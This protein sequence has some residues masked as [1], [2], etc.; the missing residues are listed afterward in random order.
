MVSLWQDLAPWEVPTALA[1]VV[2]TILLNVYFTPLDALPNSLIKTHTRIGLLPSQT[3]L[4]AQK[5]SPL[6]GSKI[7]LR[8]LWI[9]P[10][11]SC[12]GIEL[13]QSRVLPTGL[14]F[15]RLFTF[16]QLRGDETTWRFLTQR[17]AP[18]LTNLSV[19]VWLANS[20]DGSGVIV[21]KFP[22]TEK[23][24]RGWRQ[25]I[26]N[27]LTGGTY[28]KVFT[29]PL[30]FPSKGDI[31][32]KAYK[33]E[34]VKI[35]NNVTTALNMIEAVPP[36]LEKYLGMRHRLALF[37]MDPSNRREV[38]R[39]APKKEDVGYQP[40]VD[41]HDAVGQRI[42]I[43]GDDVNTP[44]YPLHLLSLNSVRDLE[45]KIEDD[46]FDSLDPRRFRSNMIMSGGKPYEEEQWT[47][48]RFGTAADNVQFHVSCRT[49]RCKMPN[50]DQDNGNR[51][52]NEPDR[53][54][55]KFR[56][57]DKGSPKYGCLGMQLC[58][59]F[60]ESRPKRDLESTV[61]VG[62]EVVPLSTGDHFYIPI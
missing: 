18:L 38:F 4:D 17:E 39:C 27:A 25:R 9:Y 54:L 35:W 59:L 28:E 6:G 13:A 24:S 44:K 11:K 5:K 2:L 10:L 52:R 41:F 53:S 29:L 36:E 51:H 30:D 61:H 20:A 1:L 12:R 42:I 62:M 34:D 8:S 15:D 16:A 57:V 43:L 21:V 37:R 60:P 3:N 40:V 32:A 47:S 22:W 55:R 45:S 46:T 31:E 50:V 23:S 19:A 14:E 26:V 49:V 56:D 7:T 58:P 48:V 33:F